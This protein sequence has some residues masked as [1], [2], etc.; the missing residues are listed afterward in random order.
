VP[1]LNEGDVLVKVAYVSQVGLA[2]VAVRGVAD[3]VL[4]LATLL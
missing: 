4:P 2:R 1:K 3:C